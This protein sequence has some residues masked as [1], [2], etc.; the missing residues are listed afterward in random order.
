MEEIIYNKTYQEY[1]A[2]LDAEM[3]GVAERFVKIGY[4]LKVA[5]DT[6][7]LSQSRYTSVTEFAKAEYG[8]D[9]SQVSRFIRINDKFAENGYSDHLLPQYQGFGSEKLGLMLQLPD[10]VNE[11]LTP[12]YSKKEIEAIKDEIKEES[13]VTDIERMIE[14]PSPAENMTLLQKVIFHLGEQEPEL[15]VQVKEKSETLQEIM[16]PAGDRT[17]TV[18]IPGI[19]RVMMILSDESTCRLVNVRSGE[20]ED[21]TWEAIEKAWEVLGLD[22]Y[23]DPKKEWSAL[24]AKDFPDFVPAQPNKTPKVVKAKPEKPKKEKEQQAPKTLHDIQPDIPEPDPVPE[25]E[26]QPEE[27]EEEPEQQLP[28]QDSVEDHPE[29]MPEDKKT[30]DS[31]PMNPP[32][33]L[34]NTESE[35]TIPVSKE[36]TDLQGIIL[37]KVEK[38]V[39][40]IKGAMWQ[41]ALMD[42]RELEEDV[43]RAQSIED[44]EAE[45][46]EV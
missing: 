15:Y 46:E 32:E 34:V 36:I 25:P 37:N 26:K 43:T 40:N 18:R 28:G 20:K 19:G 1:K 35:T 24:F 8:I 29:W 21:I 42:L 23:S 10:T 38:L 44:S 39:A 27:K 22:G 2:E 12:A 4:L 7:I 3:S 17:Y 45:D 11:V 16:A 31:Y 9:A 6:R 30:A 13:K 14:S 33:N 5:R 41:Q